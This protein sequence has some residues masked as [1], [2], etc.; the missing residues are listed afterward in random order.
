MLA[1]LVD[2]RIVERCLADVLYRLIRRAG[3]S[4]G[5]SEDLGIGE[6]PNKGYLA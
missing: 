6:L 3:G 5:T 4:Q 2:G 1:R